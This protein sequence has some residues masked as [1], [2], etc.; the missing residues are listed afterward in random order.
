MEEHR[1]KSA[2][3]IAMEKVAEMPGLP[4]EEIAEQREREY[5]PIG[6]AIARRY[7]ERA[8]RGA[9]LP[10]ELGKYRGNEGRIV[11]RALILRLCQA[12]VPG[13]RAR[14]RRTLEGIQVLAGASH[15]LEEAKR[16]FEATS[17]EF[18][19]EIKRKGETFETTEKER[20]R[21]LG[22]SGSA[23]RPNVGEREEWQQER[24]RIEQEYNSRLDK[25]RKILMQIARVA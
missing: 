9:D 17:G 21:R 18:E 15:R 14:S 4:R 7:L 19:R 2:L 5:K 8:I 23:I 6:E 20:L 24:S 22:I 11:K 25:L 13:D 16:E 3:E 1:I 10:G 12:I